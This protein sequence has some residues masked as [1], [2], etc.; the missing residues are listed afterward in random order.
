MKKLILLIAL[1]FS[2][3]AAEVAPYNPNPAIYYGPPV[4]VAPYPYYY[5]GGYYS[6]RYYV[7]PPHVDHRHR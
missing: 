7:P 6:H 1:L 2:G 4:I 3:C 5:Y